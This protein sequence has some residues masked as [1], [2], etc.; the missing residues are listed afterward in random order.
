MAAL[1]PAVT[2]ETIDRGFTQ[3]GKLWETLG[4]DT[5][6][7]AIPETEKLIYG[8]K[9]QGIDLNQG[10]YPLFLIL[11]EIFNSLPSWLNMAYY[12]WKDSLNQYCASQTEENI[13]IAER[14]ENILNTAILILK[15]SPEHMADFEIQAARYLE[16]PLLEWDGAVFAADTSLVSD[17]YENALEEL[18]ILYSAEKYTRDEISR[19]SPLMEIS[20][21]SRE[22]IEKEFL[23]LNAEIS[24]AEENLRY[25][26]AEYR[27]AAESYRN[28]GESYDALYKTTETAY[29]NLENARKVFE[30]RDAVRLWAETAYLDSGKPEDE[31]SFCREKAALAR[32]AVEI[33]ESV[34]ISNNQTR[35]YT[36]AG[37]RY[38]EDL[39][40]YI[41]ALETLY[42]YEHYLEASQRETESAYNGYQEQLSLLGK[43]FIADET[44]ISSENKALWSIK[45]VI[46][47]ENGILVFARNENNILSGCDEQR[48]K[49]LADYFAQDIIIDGEAFPVSSFELALKNLIEA[50]SGL[51]EAQYKN[52]S[53]ARDYLVRRILDENPGLD[54]AASWLKHADALREG[55]LSNMTIGSDGK[56]KVNEKAGYFEEETCILQYDA[57]NSLN[58]EEKK[59]LEFYTILVLLGGGGK[60]SGYFSL[61]SEFHEYYNAMD[62]AADS[63]RKCT[64]KSM[65]PF[66]GWIF[67]ADANKIM[68]TINTLRVPLEELYTNT[69]IGYKGLQTTLALINDSFKTYTQLSAELADM[70][71]KNKTSIRWEDIKNALTSPE[72][73]DH[74]MEP[75]REIWDSFSAETISGLKNIY[76]ALRLIADTCMYRKDESYGILAQIW[77]EG[78]SERKANETVY[79]ELYNAYMAGNAGAGDLQSAAVLGFAGNVPRQTEHLN[80]TGTILIECLAGFSECGLD[81]TPEQ[82]M[83]AGELTGLITKA[84]N[85][86]YSVEL[87]AREN[88]W[89]LQRR[90][91]QE[92]LSRWQGSAAAILERGRTAW[93]ESDEKLREACNAWIGVF[94]EE[95]GRISDQWTA[96]YLEGLGDKEAWAESALEAASQASSEAIL[97]LVGSNAEAGARAMDTRDPLSFMNL[98]DMKEG[99]KIIADLLERSGTGSLASAFSSIQGSRESLATV[100]R[101]GIGSGGAWNS[102]LIMSEA[103]ALAK[104]VGE[105]FEERESRKMA[106]MAINTAKEAYEMFGENLRL[107]NEGFREQMDEFFVM[108]GQWRRAGTD[109]IKDVIVHST[110]FTTVITDR[111]GVEGFRYFI[112]PNALLSVSRCDELLQNMNSPMSDALVDSIYGEI[113]RLF[114]DVFGSG[115]NPGEFQLYLGREPVF[116]PSGDIDLENGREGIFEDFGEGELGRLLT[117]FYYWMAM[118]QRGIAMMDVAPWDK[119]IWDSRGSK[120]NAPTLRTA[121]NIIIQTGV[122]IAGAAGAAFTGGTSFI[123]AVAISAAINTVDDLVFAAL[124]LGFGYKNWGE[125]GMEFGKNV[126]MNVAS[127]AVGAAFNGVSGA[128][129]SFLKG[130]I[131]GIVKGGVSGALW[132]GLTTGAQVFTSGAISSAVSAITFNKDGIGFSTDSFKEGIKQSAISALASSAGAF[133]SGIMN[134]GLVEFTG[135]LF[136]NGS[137][138]S[139]MAGGLATQGINY[140]FGNDFTI[141]IFNLGLITG[142]FSEKDINAG[143]LEMHMGKDGLSFQFGT[144]GADLSIG[145]LW[146]AMKGTEAYFANLR[147]LLSD[148]DAASTYTRELRALYSQDAFT[149]QEFENALSGTTRYAEWGLDFTE[150]F[151]DDDTGIKTVYLGQKALQGN[152]SM[153]LAV[154]FAHEAYRDG[155]TGTESEQILE[156]EAAIMG[157][158]RMAD[159]IAKTYGTGALENWMNAELGAYNNFLK[160]GNSGMLQTL[161][162]AYETS[163]DFWKLL[164]SGAIAYDGLATLSDADGTIIKSAGSMKLKE[165]AIETALIKILGFDPSDELAVDHV[166]SLMVSSGLVHSS[167]D[168]PDSWYWRGIHMAETVIDGEFV[169]GVMNLGNINMGEYITVSAIAGMFDSYNYYGGDSAK[170]IGNFISGVYGSATSFLFHS[171][172]SLSRYMLSNI[173]SDKQLAMIL[174]SAELLKDAAKNGIN[175]RGMIAGNVEQSQGFGVSSGK[176]KLE[177]SRVIGATHFEEDHTGIDYGPG[178]TSISVPN[179]YWEFINGDDHKAYYQLFGSDLK[180]RV[181]HIDPK[182][183]EKLI[184]GTIYGGDNSILL[185]Y[186]TQS[187]GSGSG[188][189]THIDFTMNLPYDNYYTRQFIDPATLLPKNQL[190]YKYWYF[191]KPG[192]VLESGNFIRY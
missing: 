145:T 15:N 27:E 71:G 82:S 1:A 132:K 98:P 115:D 4:I 84:W 148:Q 33:L 101:T 16:N 86:K 6:Q 125:A 138:L 40:L 13:A 100:V 122:V 44:Y 12:Q 80:Y 36:D 59:N 170:A 95:Y 23:G 35:A 169:S 47:A 87:T 130:G 166:R 178:G 188:A 73:P 78:E 140:A 10:I 135:S 157:H 102:G 20:K 96:A 167:G 66:V 114:A 83:L 38:E 147:M 19:L 119:P 31:L 67:I 5:G 184:V 74:N 17:L 30:T 22:E 121:V 29:K 56:E 55:N 28:A 144:G 185:P 90:D 158:I 37:L 69:G 154:Y 189:H 152:S 92:K 183:I 191:D 175:I 77:N 41:L 72:T 91:I 32:K 110:L 65:I 129:S 51:S 94:R 192:T 161:T 163:G 48:Y 18:Q 9:S 187:Y 26:E 164:S 60:K 179:G 58:E 70:E 103:S 159:S 186:P 79:R 63:Y 76:E 106:F 24:R 3:L 149:R 93:K 54:K 111:A 162:S 117:E 108:N 109:Y 118:E 2:K 168:D 53:L 171:D 42:R 49:I 64:Y 141:N 39:S 190:E 142:L 153:G 137:K 104:S 128:T 85:E 177:T 151:Y 116:K 43:S 25:F 172:T 182:E 81:G 133:T 7:S 143:I 160:T 113:D 89:D 112:Y 174:S 8:L 136:K 46:T 50:Y 173:Y 181:Q 99:E 62:Y 97:A 14:Q 124:D 134:M 105:D 155:I 131:S 61:E 11:D 146:S 127:A 150:S 123:G 75:I 34:N 68:A 120:F 176:I 156:S 57:W 107:A 180:M 88:E 126:V 139:Q 52:L 45:D 21:K 165:S